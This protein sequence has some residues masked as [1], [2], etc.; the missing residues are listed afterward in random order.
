MSGELEGVIRTV[1]TWQHQKTEVFKRQGY[2]DGANAASL[3]E[4]V[5]IQNRLCKQ[6]ISAFRKEDADFWTSLME[7]SVNCERIVSRAKIFVDG[8]DRTSQGM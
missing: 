2:D 8:Q 6:L 7:L 5:E 4:F 3:R 1:E